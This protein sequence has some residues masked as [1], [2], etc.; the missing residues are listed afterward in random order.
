MATHVR[1]FDAPPLLTHSLTLLTQLQRGR[2]ILLSYKPPAKVED[3][4]DAPP[5][6]TAAAAAATAATASASS[7]MRK[8]PF[9]LTSPSVVR[10]RGVAASIR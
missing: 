1:S 10:R 8:L 6:A 3:V 5:A 9:Q 2:E 7:P 4:T